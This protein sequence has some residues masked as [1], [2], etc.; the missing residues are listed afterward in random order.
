MAIEANGA[1]IGADPEIAVG[2]LGDS[3]DVVGGKSVFSLPSP[4][5]PTRL[6][7]LCEERQR[8][9]AKEDDDGSQ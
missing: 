8:K 1:C 2:S 5:I 6:V 7:V 4:V 3:G 9:R